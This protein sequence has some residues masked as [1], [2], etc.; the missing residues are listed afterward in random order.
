MKTIAAYEK[1]FAE[2][3]SWLSKNPEYLHQ[4][5]DHL[6]AQAAICAGLAVPTAHSTT[7]NSHR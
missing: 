1:W 7:E 4:V 5:P 6:K 2:Q 3:K